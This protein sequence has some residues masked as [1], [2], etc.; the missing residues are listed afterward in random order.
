MAWDKKIRK[1]QVREGGGLEEIESVTSISKVKIVYFFTP[2]PPHNKALGEL[3]HTKRLE[4]FCVLEADKR[5]RSLACKSGIL[6]TILGAGCIKLGK[7]FQVF[8]VIEIGCIC[9]G[10]QNYCMGRLEAI[11]GSSWGHI[12][13]KGGVQ[14]CLRTLSLHAAHSD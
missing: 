1:G 8:I 11:Y 10:G 9:Y 6:Y 13:Y 3:T 5:S 2:K 14:F 4:Y 12:L 7:Q